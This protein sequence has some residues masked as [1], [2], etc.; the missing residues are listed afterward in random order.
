M[1]I[2]E[3]ELEVVEPPQYKPK[4]WVDVAEHMFPNADSRTIAEVSATLA[5]FMYHI[6]L[7]DSLERPINDFERRANALVEIAQG[8]IHGAINL[9]AVIQPFEAETV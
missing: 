2:A 3:K 8:A 1:A 7:N 4:T 6:A 9:E 5:Q